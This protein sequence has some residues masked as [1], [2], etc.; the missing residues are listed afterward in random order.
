[1]RHRRAG[2]DERFV[3][4]LLGLLLLAI[5]GAV[6]SWTR[7]VVDADRETAFLAGVRAGATF[8]G[9]PAAMTVPNEVNVRCGHCGAA[10]FGRHPWRWVNDHLGSDHRVRGNWE[11]IR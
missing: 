2:A 5:T 6:G 7:T 3:A 8:S 10:Y 11:P 9:L 1:M 4:S